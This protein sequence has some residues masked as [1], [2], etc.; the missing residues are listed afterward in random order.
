V[1]HGPATREARTGGKFIASRE[2]HRLLGDV[3]EEENAQKMVDTTLG[4]NGRLD[5]LVNNAAIEINDGLV[6]MNPG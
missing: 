2:H 1:Y 3:S 5:I 4:I 6:D